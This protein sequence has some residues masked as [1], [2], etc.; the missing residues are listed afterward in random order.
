[1]GPGVFPFTIEPEQIDWAVAL[2]QFVDLSVHVS[3][4][5]FE[6]A[7][8]LRRRIV[9]PIAHRQIVMVSPVHDGVVPADMKPALLCGLGQLLQGITVAAS[10]PRRLCD[11]VLAVSRAEQGKTF[12]ML[13]RHDEIARAGFRDQG[14]PYVGIETLRR[15]PLAQAAVFAV[16]NFG[17]FLDPFGLFARTVV[18]PTAPNWL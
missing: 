4:I 9:F 13:A 11:V 17:A 8:L 6:L 16:G 10:A 3:Q 18:M 15:K 7:F 2:Q 12:V 14:G 1:M 5:T